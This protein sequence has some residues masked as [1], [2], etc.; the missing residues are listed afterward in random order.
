MFAQQNCHPISSFNGFRQ[1]ACFNCQSASANTLCLTTMV[2]NNV[3]TNGLALQDTG[4]CYQNVVASNTAVSKD[5]VPLRCANC[6]TSICK[7]YNNTVLQINVCPISRLHA[8]STSSCFN[9]MSQA[10]Q[11]FAGCGFLT[12]LHTAIFT[13]GVAMGP[14]F[15]VFHKFP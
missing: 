13:E 11:I 5:V 3:C 12:A 7:M 9:C 4:V 1:M 6:M 2:T 15:F 10:N 8:G 14:G